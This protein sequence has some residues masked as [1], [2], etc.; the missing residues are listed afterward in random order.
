MKTKF[1]AAAFLGFFLSL[2]LAGFSPASERATCDIHGRFRKLVFDTYG[3]TNA[4]NGTTYSLT[5][6]D[7]KSGE[8]LCNESVQ[9]NQ[10]I[11]PA[12]SI[13]TLIAIAV[14]R[15]IDQGRAHLSDL[16]TINQ[17]NAAG[18]CPDWNCAVY[19]PGKRVSI[20]KLIFD[21]LT[22]S[23]NLATNQLID[24]AGKAY[25]NQT[26]DLLQAPSLRIYRKMYNRVN[27]EPGVPGRNM[28]TAKGMV[29]M[30]RELSTG[31]LRVIK[32]NS[33]AHLLE[34]LRH[35]THNDGF[36]LHFP[37]NIFMYHKAGETSRTL[38]DAGFYYLGDDTVAI[39]A[40]LQGFHGYVKCPGCGMSSGMRAFQTMGKGALEISLD[41]Y[42]QIRR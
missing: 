37:K 42:P 31:R 1:S 25:I 23:N 4:L 14:M 33:R 3:Q 8:I 40:G 20:Q 28:S 22:V 5:L 2:C 10:N 41:V 19:G 12:S 17:S 6:I 21:M 35:Q 32:E 16:I 34:V 26:A 29:Q 27:P 30:Y 24:V 13:K 11:Y 9:E 38:S 36:P 18:E 7:R 39:L 15:K